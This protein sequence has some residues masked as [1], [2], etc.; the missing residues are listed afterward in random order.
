MKLSIGPRLPTKVRGINGIIDVQ[1]VPDFQEA[2][3]RDALGTYSWK[4]DK[5]EIL[6][7]LPIEKQWYIFWHEVT[8]SWLDEVGMSAV[9]SRRQ[10]EAVCNCVALGLVSMMKK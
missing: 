2:R 10:I 9:L 8:H 5:I 1:T 3:L 6:D 7:N 4:D